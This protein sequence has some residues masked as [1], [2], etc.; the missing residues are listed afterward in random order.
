MHVRIQV[1]QPGDFPRAL[2]EDG[3]RITAVEGNAYEATHPK[4]EDES[5]VR[6]RLYQLGL[7]TSAGVRIEFPIHSREAPTKHGSS[8]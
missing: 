3:W 8:R 4:V 5:D 2:R 1:L 6:D 7:L